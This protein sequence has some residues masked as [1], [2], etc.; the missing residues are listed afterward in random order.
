MLTALFL[1]PEQE[2]RAEV[3]ASAQG[4]EEVNIPKQYDNIKH[5]K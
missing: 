2:E 3:M 5:S 4:E 1:Q